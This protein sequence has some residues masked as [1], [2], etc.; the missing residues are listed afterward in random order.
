[1]PVCGTG[2]Q[3]E[4]PKAAV[5][6]IGLRIRGVENARCPPW[7]RPRRQD[8]IELVDQSRTQIKGRRWRRRLPPAATASLRARD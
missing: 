8:Q 5:P 4:D 2:F 1:M 3:N 6:A 7:R